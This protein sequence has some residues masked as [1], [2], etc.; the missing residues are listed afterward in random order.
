M[1]SQIILYHIRLITFLA[2]TAVAPAEIDETVGS[3]I[4]GLNNEPPQDAAASRRVD[5]KD[6][7]KEKER[8]GGMGK[9]ISGKLTGSGYK[10]RA[11]S[12]VARRASRI[13][14]SA[15]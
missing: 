1:A 5:A 3:L 12:N 11:R 6:A 15:S 8:G 10:R 14:D 7:K 13:R 4:W 9:L 2:P